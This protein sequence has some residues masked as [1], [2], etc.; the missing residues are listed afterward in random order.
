MVTNISIF[1][2]LKFKLP[3]ALI[4]VSYL[5]SLLFSLALTISGS[6][7]PHAKELYFKQ[8]F[9]QTLT[10]P[11]E[12]ILTEELKITPNQQFKELLYPLI[13]KSFT[14]QQN[15]QLNSQDIIIKS[16]AIV[17]NKAQLIAQWGEELFTAGD[18]GS[19]LMIRARDDLADALIGHYNSGIESISKND[20]LI[21]KPLKN[22]QQKIIGAIIS[23]QQWREGML[24]TNLLS[25]L[26]ITPFTDLLIYSLL[27]LILVIPVSFTIVFLATKQ[28]RQHL[29]H[30][31]STLNYWT[32]GELYHQIEITS[33]DEIGLCLSRLNIMA[34][35]LK[36]LIED[37]NQLASL[38]ERQYLAAELHDTV[39]QNLFSNNLS[40][41]SCKQLINGDKTEQAQIVLQQV[42]NSNQQAFSQVNQ[43]ISTLQPNNRSG[44]FSDELRTQ[45][46]LWHDNN[47]LEINKTIKVF[48]SCPIQLQ[49]VIK[50]CLGEVLQN[51]S[52][53]SQATKINLLIE[54]QKEKIIFE[55]I[56]N[57]QWQKPFKKGQGLSLM[58]HRVENIGGS[59]NANFNHQ[60]PAYSGI[61]IS[62]CLPI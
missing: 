57:G 60:T 4:L 17:D 30:L 14:L 45:L 28:L 18:I 13:N 51:I 49:H 20:Q 27:P 42:I 15:K 6:N 62:I 3:F 44:N 37:N 32:K 61:K 48:N 38:N 50:R 31:Y 9:N 12:Q 58:Q 39:K 16:I 2:S 47:P 19:Q 36:E 43:L 5:F 40:L 54:Q 7:Q 21:I 10:S 23:K 22:K 33:N 46:T 29:N 56:D 41:A 35:Q 26:T 11:I 1:R 55:I 25:F 8:W 52:K 24:D 53:H 59:F 34:T